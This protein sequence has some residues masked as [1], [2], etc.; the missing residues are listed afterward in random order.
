VCGQRGTEPLERRKNSMT[1]TVIH[2]VQTTV[3]DYLSE[4]PNVIGHMDY[5]VRGD[6]VVAHSDDGTVVINLHYD[7]TRKL[8][9]LNLPMTKV[10][11]VCA[12]FTDEK[13]NAFLE[14][15]DNAMM[16]SGGG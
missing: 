7:G 10:E 6:R 15:Y 11:I 5:E 3:G 16:R 1:K 12:G 8:G 13:A 2:K 14:H 9:S 4:I